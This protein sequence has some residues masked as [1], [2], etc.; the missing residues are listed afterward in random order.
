MAL[1]RVI[2]PMI[3]GSLDGGATEQL[4]VDKFTGDGTTV[5]FGLTRTPEG[6]NNTQVYISGVYQEKSTYSVANKDLTFSEAP[7]AGDSIEIVVAFVNPVYSGDHVKK[8]DAYNHNILINPSFTVNQ[9]GSIS[10]L[11][12]ATGFDFISDRW[13]HRPANLVG[14]GF[15]SEPIIINGQGTGLKLTYSNATTSAVFI[16]QYIEAVNV[17]PLYAKQVT[18]SFNTNN[19]DGINALTETVIDVNIWKKDQSAITCTPVGDVVNI[20]GTRYSQTFEVGTMSDANLP[21]PSTKGMSVRIHPTLNG[22]LTEWKVWNVK[23]EAG[24]VATPF[25]ARSY[26]EE[27]ALCQ[28]YYQVFGVNTIFVGRGTEADRTGLAVSITPQVELRAAPTLQSSVLSRAY[29]VDGSTSD[30][31]APL[32]HLGTSPNVYVKFSGYTTAISDNRVACVLLAQPMTLD[33]EL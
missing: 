23:L 15:S 11:A 25:I 32:N 20:G 17:Y 5:T 29:G 16:Q 30:V 21:D 19:V 31:N 27:L 9:R 2:I 18:L 3:D 22:G 7:A 1:T 4:Q 26:G 10:V 12:G 24:S 28:R 6:P 33:S 14:A 8:V 13:S